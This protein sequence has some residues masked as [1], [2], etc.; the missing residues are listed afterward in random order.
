[1]FI[2]KSVRRVGL[3]ALAVLVFAQGAVAAMGC[4][5][6]RADPHHGGVAVMPSG[7]PCDMLGDTPVAI[8]LKHSAGDDSPV[9]LDPAVPIAVVVA[10]YATLAHDMRI[11]SA[12][13]D[14]SL[15]RPLWPPPTIL[16]ARLR[17]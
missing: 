4:A 3:A 15:Q 16:F 11:E 5:T 12:P 7:E 13:P 8:A 9:S 17:D 6:L 1:M 14:I 2:A 10:L